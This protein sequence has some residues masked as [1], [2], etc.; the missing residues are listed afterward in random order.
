[1]F[2]KILIAEEH[3]IANISVQKTLHGL[4]INDTK[5]V[6]YC[7]GAFTILGF[8]KNEKPVSMLESFSCEWLS[9]GR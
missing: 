6:Y 4:G 7:D 2:N 8:S 5:Y 1:M 3:E 9:L